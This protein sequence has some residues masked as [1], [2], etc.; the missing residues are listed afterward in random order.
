MGVGGDD[1]SVSHVFGVG[2]FDT[3][4]VQNLKSRSHT[5]T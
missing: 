2:N 4:S 5:V 1:F 3:Q